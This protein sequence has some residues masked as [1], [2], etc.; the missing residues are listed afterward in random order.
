MAGSEMRHLSALQCPVN[1]DRTRSDPVSA[2]H[3][4]CVLVDALEQKVLEGFTAVACD[5]ASIVA[6]VEGVNGKDVLKAYI[7]NA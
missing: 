6:S 2:R 3:D 4:G 5:Y 1:G 7:F